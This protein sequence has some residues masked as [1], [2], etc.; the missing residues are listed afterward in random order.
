MTRVGQIGEATVRGVVEG[1]VGVRADDENLRRVLRLTRV[2]LALA[3][4]GERDHRD[5][6]CAILYG[7]LRD[8]AYRLRRMADEELA[9]HDRAERR[10]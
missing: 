8:M 6:S 7:M 4:E 10:G 2:M 1:A 5:A 3:D 9:R